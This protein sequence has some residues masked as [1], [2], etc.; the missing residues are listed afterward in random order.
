MTGL[1]SLQSFARGAGVPVVL[2]LSDPFIVSTF[3]ERVRALLEH[4]VDLLFCN[5]SEAQTYTES[6]KTSDACGILARDVGQFAVTRGPG[7][8]LVWDGESSIAVSGFPVEAV[9]TN[10]AGDLF[11]GAFLF[12]VTN[13]YDPAQSAKLATYASSRVVAKYG[14]RLDVSLKGEVERILDL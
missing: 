9:D 3:R 14:P 10:G 1:L 5:E 8:A 4:G 7:G 13:G 6:E 12:G 11:A 2:T